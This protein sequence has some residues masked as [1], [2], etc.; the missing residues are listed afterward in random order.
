M[1]SLKDQLQEGKKRFQIE[2]LEERIA[3]SAA[4]GMATAMAN[5]NSHA[6]NGLANAAQQNGTGMG[7]GGECPPD[8]I[9]C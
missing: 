1:A 8:D 6:A 9:F 4:S 7:G 2:K 3:P 5:A